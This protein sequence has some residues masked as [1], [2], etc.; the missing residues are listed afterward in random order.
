[1]NKFPLLS[2]VQHNDLA[3]LQDLVAKSSNEDANAFA[4][5]AYRA[6][7]MA[8]NDQ[9]VE[10]L[11]ILLP[12]LLPG[13]VND[14]FCLCVELQ[15]TTLVHLLLPYADPTYEDSSAL[16]LASALGNTYLFDLLYPLSNPKKALR[17]MQKTARPGRTDQ[18]KMLKERIDTV[19]LQKKLERAAKPAQTNAPKMSQGR[20]L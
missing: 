1:M 15:D 17:A 13:Q 4:K 2:A 18:W 19:A 6:G 3:Q 20:K 5:D 10:G 7:I 8:V 12:I 9:N 11:S 16:Q 14:L